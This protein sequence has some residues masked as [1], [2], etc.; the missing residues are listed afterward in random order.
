MIKLLDILESKQIGTIYHFTSVYALDSMMQKGNIILDKDELSD[1]ADGYYSFTRYSNLSSLDPLKR[2]VRIKLNGDKMSYKYKFSPYLDTKS[3][4]N[5]KT[6]DFSKNSPNFEAEERIDSK[7]YG[8]INLTNYIINIDIINRPDFLKQLSQYYPE[9]SRAYKEQEQAW[10][11]AI[12]KMNAYN[13]PFS[14]W[15]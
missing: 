3:L 8:N 4:G 1:V 5:K 9:N 14:I 2:H 7:K 11:N 12:K 6:L 13:T 15:K 10:E